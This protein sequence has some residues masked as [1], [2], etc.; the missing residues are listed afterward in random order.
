[1]FFRLF[2]T[3]V[4]DMAYNE[5]T[6]YRERQWRQRGRPAGHGR[7]RGRQHPLLRQ[8][9]TANPQTQPDPTNVTTLHGAGAA[10]VATYFGCWLDFNHNIPIRNQ[11]RGRHQCLVAEIHYLPSPI[12]AGATPANN[13][14][15]SQRNLAIVESDNPGGAAA[16]TVAHTFEVKPSEGGFVLNREMGGQ[17]GNLV[18]VAR[19]YGPDELFIRWNGL[20][21]DS[22]ATIYLPGVQMEEFLTQTIGR[23]GFDSLA[24]IDGDTIRCRVGDATYL[25]LP[26]GRGTNLPGLLTIELPPTVRAGTTYTVSVHQVSGLRHNIIASFDVAVLV[27]RAPLLVDAARRDLAVLRQIGATIPHGNRWEPVFA[28]YLDVLTDR[29]RAFGGD[30]NTSPEPDGNG[31]PQPEDG[32]VRGKVVTILYDCF[33]D[34]EG[35]ILDTCCG[36]RR[37]FAREHRLYEALHEAS[38]H[39]LTVI[40]TPCATF[41]NGPP[42]CGSS[43]TDRSGD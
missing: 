27:S 38:V 29:I 4:T 20:P 24:V 14:Q 35:F 11:I 40:V 43:T 15:L 28:R 5:A 18:A 6:I 42:Q 34:F 3:A 32:V 2:T 12:P 26:A 10:E 16:H 25:P 9:R 13:D 41:P 33:G 30:P 8:H 7:W 19:A 36:R 23:P 17:I 31:L 22:V 39:R 37:F 1:M 21:R